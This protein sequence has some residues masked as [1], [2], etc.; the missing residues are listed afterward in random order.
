MT[1]GITLDFWAYYELGWGGWWFWDPVEN[2]SL[3]PWLLLTALLL[4]TELQK[5]DN[6]KSWT[7]LLSII[8]FSTL[9]G[10]F[11]VRSGLLTSVHAFASDPARGIYI[12][13]FLFLITGASLILY[14]IKYDKIESDEKLNLLSKEGGLY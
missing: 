9:L 2:V 3:L 13:S 12:L 14:V 7:I 8:A 11:I 6:L 1:L 4:L 5:R 10:T